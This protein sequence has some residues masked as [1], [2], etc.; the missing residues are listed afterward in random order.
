METVKAAITR[1]GLAL[2]R[3]PPNFETE[4]NRFGGTDPM[5][6]L[7][8]RSACFPDTS[9]WKILDICVVSIVHLLDRRVK[10]AEAKLFSNPPVP[11]MIR[12]EVIEVNVYRD[13]LMTLIRRF[14][15]CFSEIMVYLS[16]L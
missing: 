9:S 15:T 16:R 12:Y 13:I 5:D 7:K 1:D 3:V 8:F 4:L 11:E 2:A 10:M 6:I 14:L